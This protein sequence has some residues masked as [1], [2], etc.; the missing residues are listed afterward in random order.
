MRPP[1]VEG[2]T[3]YIPR[4]ALRIWQTSCCILTS[5]IRPACAPSA[6]QIT[7][8]APVQQLLAQ[9]HLI[10]ATPH[11]GVSGWESGE[12]TALQCFSQAPRCSLLG[13]VVHNVWAPN[14]YLAYGPMMSKSSSSLL[15]LLWIIWLFV[16]SDNTK[17]LSFRC[18]NSVT[19][20]NVAPAANCPNAPPPPTI[21]LLAV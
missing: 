14:Q 4:K 7:Q 12:N 17:V 1:P 3:E 13:V 6:V 5:C 2:P 15:F 9:C 11:R 10:A 21:H 16:L 8:T 20:S 18:F 19:A